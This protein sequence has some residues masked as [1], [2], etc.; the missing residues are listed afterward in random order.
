[1]QENNEHNTA[2]SINKHTEPTLPPRGAAGEPRSMLQRTPNEYQYQQDI[3]TT[4]HT[5]QTTT[6][7]RNTKRGIRSILQI[8]IRIN[9]RK[10]RR[11]SKRIAFRKFSTW[12]NSLRV[13]AT[14]HL[15]VK[16]AQQ[17]QNRQTYNTTGNNTKEQFHIYWQH[18]RR[19]QKHIK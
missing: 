8:E 18:T 14:P 5:T 13:G 11:K 16:V 7:L 2:I 4:T 1:M 10:T 9:N 6:R 12:Y 15:S 17:P 19:I 3:H